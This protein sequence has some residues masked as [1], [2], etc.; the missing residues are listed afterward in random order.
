MEREL[1]V[2]WSIAGLVDNLESPSI[3]ETLLK[4]W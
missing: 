4:F 2:Y 1:T 3:R